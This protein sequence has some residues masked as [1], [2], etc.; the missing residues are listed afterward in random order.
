MTCKYR[1]QLLTTALASAFIA[2]A[3]YA[4]ADVAEKSTMQRMQPIE[5]ELERDRQPTARAGDVSDWGDWKLV[6]E[7]YTPYTD[8]VAPSF[9]RTDT[10]RDAG[11]ESEQRIGGDRP[12]S[13]LLVVGKAAG[14]VPITGQGQSMA[15]E[16]S[17]TAIAERRVEF[18]IIPKPSGAVITGLAQALISEPSQVRIVGWGAGHPFAPA[19]LI[20][21]NSGT[22]PELSQTG[23]AQHRLEKLTEAQTLDS[24]WQGTS[25]P[26]ANDTNRRSETDWVIIF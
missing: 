12:F 9:A 16:L 10:V 25:A 17:Q 18:G 1:T 21:S 6:Y 15:S 7:G 19:P 3:P 2:A 26:G 24:I 8:F 22:T 14:G 20:A 11:T 13:S 5:I 4:H 23:L